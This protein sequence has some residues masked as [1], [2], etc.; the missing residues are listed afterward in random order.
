MIIILYLYIF[1]FYILFYF[2]LYFKTYQKEH[3]GRMVGSAFMFTIVTCT[4]EFV[5]HRS[6]LLDPLQGLSLV[7]M[8][9]DLNGIRTRD[10]DAPLMSSLSWPGTLPLSHPTMCFKIWKKTC[11]NE[12]WNEY[13]VLADIVFLYIIF[14]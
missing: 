3:Q 10:R 6:D 5:L 8:R 2:I 13:R 1:I 7:N 9:R 11:A 4:I 14:K 12:N